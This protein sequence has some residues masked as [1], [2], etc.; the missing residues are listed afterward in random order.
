MKTTCNDDNTSLNS[1][2][3]EMF[4]TDVIEKIKIH[5]LCSM[6]IRTG[7]FPTKSRVFHR[8]ATWFD[9]FRWCHGETQ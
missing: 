3:N 7:Y 2:K 6:R 8:S 9:V 5:I 4:E 1:S